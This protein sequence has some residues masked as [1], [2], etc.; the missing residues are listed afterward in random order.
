MRLSM[1]VVPMYGHPMG[2][3]WV[4]VTLALA[5][6]KSGVI[7]GAKEKFSQKYTCPEDSV[8]AR[9]REDVTATQLQNRKRD[10]PSAEVAADPPRLALWKKEQSESEARDKNDHV[11]EARGCGHLEIYSC[12]YAT[13][14]ASTT[15]STRSAPREHGCW[16]WKK[17][18][19]TLV[20]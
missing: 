12:G 6:C 15:W 7:D 18:G 4:A 8:E 2:T 11:V 13:Q 9:L 20:R 10:A 16:E 19:T 14:H 1:R 5:A 3:R 17:V